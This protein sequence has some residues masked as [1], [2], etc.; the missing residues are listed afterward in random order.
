M[1]PPDPASPRPPRNITRREMLRLS[2]LGAG[3]LLAS[4]FWPGTLFANHDPV[5]T[6]PIDFQFAVLNDLHYRDKRCGEWFPK[7]V[8]NILQQ[9]PR[10]QFCLLA[11]D[12]AENGVSAQLGPVREIFATLGMPVHTIIGNHDHLPNGDCSAFTQLFGNRLNQRFEHHDWQFLTLDTTQ[13]RSVYRTKISDTTLHWL[14]KTLPD[15]DKKRPLVICTHFPLGWNLLRPLNASALLDRLKPY[16]LR[17]IYSGHW[18]GISEFHVNHGVPAST[19]RCAS[20]WRANHDFSSEH[21]YYL[22][23]ARQGTI[24]HRFI[25]V[26]VPSTLS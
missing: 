22:C 1:E 12:I 4:G 11:G 20:W 17:S 26:P 3:G 25:Y 21:G 8:A 2:A 19:D 15:I 13:G 18:H 6:G 16:N 14:D 10:P 7:L 5:P 24:S 9:K 23:T